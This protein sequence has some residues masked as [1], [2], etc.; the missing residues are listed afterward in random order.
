MSGPISILLE[1]ERGV[2]NLEITPAYSPIDISLSS[3]APL[4]VGAITL[5]QETPIEIELTPGNSVLANPITVDFS[6][7]SNVIPI[8]IALNVVPLSTIIIPNFVAGTLERNGYGEIVAV[9]KANGV[10]V[11]LER[12]G[13]GRIS[14]IHKNG[15][16]MEFIRDIEGVVTSWEVGN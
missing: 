10:S 7:A 13:L 3:N 4:C 16:T 15:R 9:N 8:D 6:N 2:I 5:V 14:K 1:D 12:D 11:V